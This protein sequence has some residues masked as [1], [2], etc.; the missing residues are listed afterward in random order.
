[1]KILLTTVSLD[2]QKGGG[3]AERTRRLAS[4]L[5]AQGHRCEIATIQG[6][7]LADKL[8]GR[9]MQ[10]YVT[11]SIRL[12]L[13]VPL[14]NPLRL[15]R[16]VRDADVIH[17]LGYWNLLSIVTAFL[18]ARLGKPYTFS[19]AGEFVGLDRP[20]PIKHL[21][22]VLVGQRMIRGAGL[23]IAITPLERRQ[24]LQR[25][26]LSEDRVIVI[27]NGVEEQTAA[28]GGTGTIPSAPYIL[29]VGRLAE[30]K[31]PD[32][33]VSAFG[34]VATQY[35]DVRLVIAGPDFGMRRDLESIVQAEQLIDRVVFTSHLGEIERND[36]YRGA[37]FLVVPSRAEAMSLVALEAGIFGTPVLLTD[38]CGFDEVE[39][40]GGGRVVAATA[41]GLYE[42]LRSMLAERA[43]LP[44]KGRALQAYVRR[45]FAWPVIVELLISH[46]EGLIAQ[47]SCVS[48][49]AIMNATIA[50]AT[51]ERAGEDH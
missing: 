42:G 28:M 43:S 1:M 45:N 10:V 49:D 6:G 16:S 26:Q 21:F 34:K 24:I 39:T 4:H 5:S 31:G 35:G 29:F 12:R 20:R 2:S 38:Q 13:T 17:I 33:L 22:H 8:R 23:L 15:M 19:A 18:A 44:S 3:T 11:G 46:F 47:K 36:A 48:G 27:P 9:S 25:F 7:D 30:V 14:I 40:V 37:L 50:R 41:E 32:L 51:D